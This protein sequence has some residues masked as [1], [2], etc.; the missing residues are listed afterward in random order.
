MHEYHGQNI[1][2]A[3]WLNAGNATS[4]CYSMSAY[5]LCPWSYTKHT[6]YTG[7]VQTRV[8]QL[9]VIL[10]QWSYSG[11]HL[12]ISAVRVIVGAMLGIYLPDH[13]KF[14]SLG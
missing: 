2:L 13:L 12:S 11:L 8:N 1:G 14:C 6:S 10:R 3:Q 5:A 4:V 9:R 7:A